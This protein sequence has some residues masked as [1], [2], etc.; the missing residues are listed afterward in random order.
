MKAFAAALDRVRASRS[1]TAKE[2]ILGEA[3]AAI[4]SLPS[5]AGH[6]DLSLATAARLASGRTLPVGD[7]RTLG[8]GWALVGDLVVETTGQDANVVR[9]CARRAGDL[10][11]AFGLLMARRDGAASRE[12]ASMTEVAIAFD[13]LASTPDRSGKL[14][15]LRAL[16]ERA[17]PLETKYLTKALLSSLRIGAQGGVVEAAIAHAFARDPGEVRRALALTG[18]PGIVASLARAD[19]LSEARSRSVGR[20]NTCWRRRLRRWPRRLTRRPSSSRTRSM[21]FERRSTGAARRVAMFCA[22]VGAGH[23]GVSRGARCVFP[24]SKGTWR[25]TASSSRWRRAVAPRPFQALQTR[26]NRASPTRERREATPV[27]FIAYDLLADGEGTVL[28]APLERASRTPGSVCART[29]SGRIRSRS[30]RS[31]PSGRMTPTRRSMPCS[32]RPT[33]PRA[34]AAT[35]G[36]C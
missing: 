15:I 2:R 28:G 26:L 30:P 4:A 14:A 33:R 22:R 6:E 24:R 10:G 18:D 12:G 36:W 20:W 1:R 8:V 13:A 32:T 7:G 3:F 19:R 16:F 34:A 5:S 31:R 29:P 17:T 23:G 27:T 21:G 9:A 35:R 25:S 11:E